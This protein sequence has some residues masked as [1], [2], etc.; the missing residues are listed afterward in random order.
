MS[1][2]VIESVLEIVPTSF[3]DQDRIPEIPLDLRDAHVPALCVLLA[4]E[5]EILVLD[6]D[7]AT[8]GTCARIFGLAVV[9]L[10]DQFPE[11]TVE[12][13]HALGGDEN[14][15]AGVAAGERLGHLEKSAPRIFLQV[16]VVLLIFCE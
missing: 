14:L 1:E 3:R 5:E 13:V 16:D 15:E 11:L 8:C 6:L 2:E 12:L 9:V 4:C 7:V 10:L